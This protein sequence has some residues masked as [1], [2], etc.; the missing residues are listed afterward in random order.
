LPRARLHLI[1]P[2][3]SLL[4]LLIVGCRGGDEPSQGN[5][6]VIALENAPIHLD[7][8]LGSDQ[9]SGRVYELM[10]NGLVTKDTD[11]NFIPGLAES[12]EILDRGTR[13]RFHLR[14]GVLFHDGR[15]LSSKDVAWTFNSMVEGIVVSPKRGGFPQLQQVEAIDDLTV[16]FL[17]SEPWGALLGNVTCFVGILPEGALPEDFNRNPIGSGPYRL[18]ER[19]PDRL[20]FEAFEHYWGSQPKIERVI[21]REVPDATVRALEL[22]KGSVQLIINGLPPDVVDDFVGDPQYHVQ[23]DAGSSYQYLGLNLEDPVLRNRSVRQA[24]ARAIDRAKILKTLH[25]GLGIL[26]ETA[27]RP[28]HWA[29]NEKLPAITF[30]PAE[31]M[32]LLDQA[33]FQD[34]DGNGPESRFSLTYKTSTDETAVLQ[35]QI[36]QS[37]LAK[38]GIE[39]QIRSFEFATFYNDVKQGNF[40]MFSLAWTG[41]DDPDIYSLILHSERIPPAGA[42]RGRY[43]N[44]EFDRLIDQGAGLAEPQLRRPYYLKAQEILLDEL[45]YISLLLKANVAIMPCTLEGYSNYPSGELYGVADISWGSGSETCVESR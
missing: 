27:L 38:V 41:I 20:T 36:I 33:G 14:P 22:K 42:N 31:A 26:T 3:V 25:R 17:L 35:A 9:A 28:G 19:L 1:T 10:L 18:I 7:P 16:D 5:E 32:R 37:M 15:E 21:L 12:W 11:G 40:Q 2:A 34:P 24:I 45:P 44:R 29:R 43:R 23:V 8:R 30:D 39:V 4:L 6:L 13:Y